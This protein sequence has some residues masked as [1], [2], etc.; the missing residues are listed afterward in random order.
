MQGKSSR[1]YDK[2]SPAGFKSEAKLM[3]GIIISLL[4]TLD[5]KLKQTELCNL[6]CQPV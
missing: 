4:L 5:R 1:I 6:G 3:E 2:K